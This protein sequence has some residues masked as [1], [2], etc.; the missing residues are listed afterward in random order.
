MMLRCTVEHCGVP[1]C[2]QGLT[3]L[4][5]LVFGYPDEYTILQTSIQ[6]LHIKLNTQLIWNRDPRI[7]KPLNFVQPNIATSH[8]P[9]VHQYSGD[10]IVVR[11]NYFNLVNIINRQFQLKRSMIQG[12]W[13]VQLHQ[14]FMQK[15]KYQ[16]IY[17]W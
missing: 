6:H 9:R 13:K 15:V 7:L 10:L 4:P 1:R 17:R 8:V 16:I 12:Y 3:P 5:S 14:Y 11:S 2:A